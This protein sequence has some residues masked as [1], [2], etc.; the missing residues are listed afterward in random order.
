MTE[1]KWLACTEP[2]RML[3]HLEGKASERQFRLFVCACWRSVWQ[4]LDQTQREVIPVNEA[5]ADR[6]R[7][8]NCTVFQTLGR[9]GRRVGVA[10]PVRADCAAAQAAEARSVAA[11]AACEDAETEF[12]EVGQW[13]R[14]M[15]RTSRQ[16]CDVVR[17]IFGNPFRPTHVPDEWRTWNDGTLVKMA[18]SI[19]D[20][21]RWN[22][23]PILADALEDAGC[24]D[25]LLLDHCRTPP[26]HVRGC[27]VLDALLDLD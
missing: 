8:E 15:H 11:S 12:E 3:E 16:Q 17:C 22:E 6:Y 21:R 18:R 19:Y 23:M 10:G 20:G 13:K 27:H 1:L 5:S 2:T 9:E 25:A 24:T 26:E 4:L 14:A 7:S